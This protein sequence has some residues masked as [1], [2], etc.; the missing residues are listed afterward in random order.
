MSQQRT[1]IV[2]GSSAGIGKETAKLLVTEGWR[3]IG[4]ARDPARSAA[5]IAEIEAA[6]AQGGNFEMLRG[7]FCNMADVKR[8][9]DEIAARTSR[10]DVLINNAGGVRDARYAGAEGLEAMLAANH[11]APW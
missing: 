3:V 5:A 7:D 8:V 11:V 9:A 1:A 6:C 4:T 10:I 2:T